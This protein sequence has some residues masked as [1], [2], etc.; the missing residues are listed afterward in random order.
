MLGI[1]SLI[2]RAKL[3]KLFSQHVMNPKEAF[4]Y[5]VLESPIQSYDCKKTFIGLLYAWKIEK[6]VLIFVFKMEIPAS[7][8]SKR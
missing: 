1:Q 8:L 3:I 2:H 4:Y 5:G 7:I 6:E